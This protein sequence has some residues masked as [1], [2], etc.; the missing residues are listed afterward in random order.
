LLAEVLPLEKTI[1]IM[2]VDD[3]DSVR[4]VVSE[5]LVRR[6]WS[7]EQFS[8]AE[9]AIVSLKGN[10]YDLI[11]A[12]INMPGLSGMDLLQIAKQTSPEV[13]FI[14]ITGYPSLDLAVEAMKSGATDFIAKPFKAEEIEIA[15]RKAVQGA[16]VTRRGPEED[17]PNYQAI[18]RLPDIAR[19]RLE[20]KIKELS[21]LHTI[22][23]S[24]DE[25]SH[26]EGIFKKTLDLAQV[27][28]G[29]DRS[30]IM[31]VEQ[32]GRE[33]AVRA[34][35][36]YEDDSLLGLSFSATEEPFRGVLRN[37][38]YSYLLVEQEGLRP[39]VSFDKVTS[40]RK[41]LFLAP[42]LMNREVVLILGLP[43][44]GGASEMSEDTITLLLNLCAKASLKLENIALSENIFSSI[45]GAL[46]SLINALDARDT[47]TKDHSNR[48]TK[49]AL[50]LARTMNCG[51]D[52]LDSIS[53]AGPLHDIGKIGIRDEVLLKKG[54]FSMDERELMKLHVTRGEEIL[55]PLNLLPTE[56]A[57][58]L[59]HHERWDG[60]GYPRGL[61]N[62]E[63]P[64]V[65]RIFSVADT[66]DA[67]TSSR[68]Y[69]DALGVELAR[70][71]IMRCRGSQFD[72]DVVDAFFMSSIT[73]VV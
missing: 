39:L 3:D 66:F 22:G 54:M 8:S 9:T 30:F 17:P 34:T 5:I 31:V 27:I 38:C 72:P 6:G 42:L 45:I 73:K 40:R 1:R 20:D 35:S 44:A 51:Q 43:D 48:V 25:V 57:V 29:S 32:D 47:Y 33:V 62:G 58:V 19:R 13:P 14:M 69:R 56:R 64:F 55:R 10:N 60:A 52:I 21:I 18:K 59:Y 2:L 15:V 23:E 71:E 65:A 46:N 36:G 12:D 4:D 61:K 37:R 68:P 67:M 11:M 63:I 53:F 24:L 41:P 16:K 70:A 28:T 49:Y 50:H 26:K 7:V